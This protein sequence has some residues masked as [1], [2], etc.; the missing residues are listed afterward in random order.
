MTRKIPYS[1][2]AKMADGSRI[3]QG[4]APF[5]VSEDATA[6]EIEQLILE[7]LQDRGDIESVVWS[8]MSDYN[9]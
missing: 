1:F 8:R 3:C 5:M 4:D 9:L 7:H 6:R 2:S